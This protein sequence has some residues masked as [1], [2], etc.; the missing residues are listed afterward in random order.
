MKKN[1]T[2]GPGSLD[3]NVKLKGI[4]SVLFAQNQIITKFK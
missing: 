3:S 2:S 1:I 4:L